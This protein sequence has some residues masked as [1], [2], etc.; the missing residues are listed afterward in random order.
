MTDKM[1]RAITRT[2]LFLGSAAYDI[3]HMPKKVVQGI[4]ETHEKREKE[5][6]YK[7]FEKNLLSAARELRGHG[8]YTEERLDR[9]LPEMLEAERRR[10]LGE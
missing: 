4:K 3:T 9:I 10:I 7:E 1:E 6:R 2:G 8:I 5:K